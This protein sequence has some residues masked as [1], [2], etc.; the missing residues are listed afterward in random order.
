[1]TQCAQ[2]LRSRGRRSHREMASNVIAA[3][4]IVFHLVSVAQFVVYILIKT[5]LTSNDDEFLEKLVNADLALTEVSYLLACLALPWAW[6][7]G[8]KV[9]L[10]ETNQLETNLKLAKQNKQRNIIKYE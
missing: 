9:P 10:N 2:V 4:V 6:L 1:M 3:A 5:S 7:L 8:L